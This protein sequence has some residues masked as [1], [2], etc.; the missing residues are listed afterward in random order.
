MSQ[1]EKPTDAA[2]SRPPFRFDAMPFSALIVWIGCLALAVV[3]ILGSLVGQEWIWTDYALVDRNPLIGML[4]GLQQVWTGT[5]HADR[6]LLPQYSPLSQTL[7]FFERAVF[8]DHLAGYRVVSALLHGSCAAVLYLI[9]RGLRVRGAIAVTLLFVVHPVLVD[10]VAFLTE[11]RNV[12][13]GFLGL[14]GFYLLLRAAGAIA[15]PTGKLKLLPDEP[16]RLY[17]MGAALSVLALFAQPAV[18]GLGLVLLLVLWARKDRIPAALGLIAVVLAV[19]GAVLVS[20][21]SRVELAHSPYTAKQWERAPSVGGEMAVRT[22]VAGRAVWFYLQKSFLPYPLSMDYGRWITPNDLQ[23]FRQYSPP[24][25]KERFEK[26]V[27]DVSPDRLAAWAFPAGVF[28]ALVAL[29]AL[30]KQIGR[31]PFALAASFLLLL[32]PFLGFVDLGWMQYSF[33]SHRALYLATIVP[34]VGVV[35]LLTPIL[36]QP[37]QR[38]SMI[39]SLVIVML[40][41]VRLGVGVAIRYQYNV[42]FWRES[43]IAANSRRSALN[44]LTRTPWY[45]RI[46]AA[47]A[48]LNYDAGRALS[49]PV[50]QSRFDSRGNLRKAYDQSDPEAYVKLIASIPD[51]DL[52]GVKVFMSQ[53]SAANQVREKDAEDSP[54]NGDALDKFLFFNRDALAKLRPGNQEALLSLAR[55][56]YAWRQ[57]G[58]AM[59]RL[60]FVME[61]RPNFSAAHRAAGDI[62]RRLADRTPKDPGPRLATLDYYQQAAMANPLDAKARVLVAETAWDIAKR[63]PENDPK[64]VE[65]WMRKAAESFDAAD[66]IRPYDVEQLLRESKALIE[67]NLL[68]AAASRLKLANSI[69]PRNLDVLLTIADASMAGGQLAGAETAFQNVII[70]DDQNLKAYLNYSQMLATQQRFEDSERV[71]KK[72]LEKLPDNP[73]LLDAMSKLKEIRDS[74]TQPSS[75]QASGTGSASTQAVETPQR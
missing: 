44:F 75:T 64:V 27:P 20:V 60:N 74:A 15:P 13:G 57:D 39:A 40:V 54:E 18:A 47:N 69:E 3:C 73:E 71:L 22:Q 19:L 1:L 10:S 30:K 35:M 29:W 46:Q 31:L 58:E 41:M 37:N 21:S 26:M 59:S 16:A 4:N 49:H 48:L 70:A 17:F 56:L 53:M 6:Y 66:E 5:F 24:E 67:M 32:L 45:S 7:F 52:A 50:F 42:T 12:L 72:G 33:V 2:D 9:L 61:E 55:V 14:S 8:G 28:I 38:V 23:D 68:P 62:Q 65:S 51:T 25:S 11:R 63:L 34:L 43:D 36:A